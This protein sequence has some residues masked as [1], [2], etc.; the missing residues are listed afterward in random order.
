MAGSRG[1]RTAGWAAA[2][3]VLLGAGTW[4]ALR[5][6]GPLLAPEWE[7]PE[8]TPVVISTRGHFH[9]GELTAT[10]TDYDY[11]VRGALPGL[12][13]GTAPPADLIITVHGFNNTELKALSKFD[14]AQA[15]LRTAGY[16]GALVGYSW[17][18]DTQH[19]P[20]SATGYRE[21][22]RHAVGN[23]PKLARFIL[24]YRATCPDT[25]VH[26]I[27]YSMGAR[28]ALEALLAADTDE[29]L[30]GGW[31][32][33]TVHLVGAAVDNEEVE[34]GERYGAA[35]ERRC[36]VL[37]NYFSPA[38]SKLA[39]FFPFKEGDRALG[40]ADIEHADRAPGNYRTLDVRT[41]LISYDEAGSPE[42]GELGENHSGYLG[43]RSPG[44]ELLDDGVM[45]LVAAEIAELGTAAH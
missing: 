31:M 9:D 23:G 45:D 43:N 15:G 5:S 35:I 8:H 10:H 22:R 2:V 40:Q 30:G 44:G 7:A 41:E 36:R 21:G 13:A 37:V 29:A 38:D 19:D 25:R 17:D 42:P 24:D 12:A 6:I 28:V 32:V 27:G 18:A 39:M 14:T 26:L 3:V 1:A 11:A 16:D 4:L 33:D 34:L 20:L